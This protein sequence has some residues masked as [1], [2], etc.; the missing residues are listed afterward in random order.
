MNVELAEAAAIGRVQIIDD[1]LHEVR[2]VGPSEA[3]EQV[4]P[5]IGLQ[6]PRDQPIQRRWLETLH[7]L[8]KLRECDFHH[9]LPRD[10]LRIELRR[11]IGFWI[12]LLALSVEMQIE[13][14]GD[15]RQGRFRIL[16][17]AQERLAIL[18]FADAGGVVIAIDPSAEASHRPAPIARGPDSAGRCRS[19]IPRCRESVA[20][21]ARRGRLPARSLRS[22]QS[23]L[24]WP[25]GSSTSI[26]PLA[27]EER[28]T[29]SVSSGNGSW[30][31]RS[32]VSGWRWR[33]GVRRSSNR[34]KCS[35]PMRHE[36]FRDQKRSQRVAARAIHSTSVAAGDGRRSPHRHQI[37]AGTAAG[38][39][40]ISVAGDWQA[41][42]GCGRGVTSSVQTLKL[43]S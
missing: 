29:H 6:F 2:I 30:Q 10:D 22:I 40:V 31:R 5:L 15:Q 1:Q 9:P 19:R 26:R 43:W 41:R 42:S 14:I 13:P 37:A 20:S 16:A 27:P 7:R 34:A 18:D 21:T 25:G 11:Q 24:P 36:K 3:R 8:G 28:Q 33:N 17:V 39:Q 23:L 32:V 35:T 4:A 38:G 12:E